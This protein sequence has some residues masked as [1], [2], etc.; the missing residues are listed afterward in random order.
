M[1]QTIELAADGDGRITAVRV[2]L[3]RRHGRVPAAGHAGD[4]AARRVH[5]P[6]RL[7]RA[8]V[9]VRVHRRVHQQDADRRVPRC[10][11]RP[12]A[13]Y[14]IERAVDALAR[15]M[16]LDPVEIRRR[17]FIPTDKFPYTIDR[18]AAVRQRRTTNRALD[19]RARDGRLRRA[20]RRAGRA[21]ARGD[22]RTSGSASRATSRCAASRRAAC[23]ASLNYRRRRLGGTR[24][25]GSCPPARCRSSPA[26]RRTVRATRPCWSMIVGRLAS[27]CRPTTSRCCT[28]TPPSRRSGST[29]TGSRSLS[30]GGTALYLAR[31]TRSS[32]RRAT[33]AA[34]QLE[35]AEDDL[36]FVDGEFRVR[37][38]RRPGRWRS[39][40]SRSRRSPRTTCPTAWSRTSRDRSSWDP[41]NFTFPFGVHIAVVEIDEETGVVEPASAT[42]PST[43][44]ATRSTR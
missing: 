4:P 6:R 19:A 22:P 3:A 29:P 34:H 1:I 28:P 36:E 24:R 20:A 31:P 10:A 27:A 23:S 17:N 21:P 7:R 15:A 12:E 44:A 2:Q 32:R 39:G 5:L 37:R 40:A 11:G 35:V 9:L 38:A 43:T 14:A 25:C 41:P 26:P 33:I 30:V 13:T 18:G 16:D 42:S 8:R